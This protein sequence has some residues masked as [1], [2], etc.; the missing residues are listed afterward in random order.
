MNKCLTAT[1]LAAFFI[2]STRVAVAVPLLQI[3]LE[4]GDYNTITESWSLTPQG[5][6]G[7]A[8]FR[9]WTIGNTEGPN[10][11]G[12]ILDV[13]LS[14]A[15]SLD[16]SDLQLQLTP[17]K[18]GGDGSYQGFTDPSV[19]E[20]PTL[21]TGLIPTSLGQFDAGTMGIVTNGGSPVLHGGKALPSHGIFGPGTVWR[22][23][24]LGDFTLADSPLGDFIGSF[25]TELTQNAAQINVYEVSVVGGSGATVHFDLYNHVEAKN[26]GKF[27]PFSHDGDGDAHIIPEP[28]T[29]AVWSVLSGLGLLVGA[30]RGKRKSKSKFR[31]VA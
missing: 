14:I 5:S 11:K 2:L 17:S 21:N 10:S 29:L 9:L 6:S 7:G 1:V 18:A 8:P 31:R 30:R 19:P 27:A 12:D 26:H 16:H 13:R 20:A 15:Y 28:S 3:Y 25:P 23:Y 24:S 4:G 22:E